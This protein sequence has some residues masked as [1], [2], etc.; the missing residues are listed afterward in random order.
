MLMFEMN[1][2]KKHFHIKKRLKNKET[3]TINMKI[4]IYVEDSDD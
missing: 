1:S 3:K 4:A 2:W